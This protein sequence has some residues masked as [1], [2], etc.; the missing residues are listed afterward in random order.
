MNNTRL[1]IGAGN[2]RPV[3][4]FTLIEL[5]VVVAIIALL[6]AILVPALSDARELAKGA[7][8]LGRLRGIG[9]ATALYQGEWCILMW[10]MN[11]VR[12]W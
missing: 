1:A 8:C 4:G 6:V 7:V 10:Q 12:H 2:D 3:E 5:L 11:I 9:V